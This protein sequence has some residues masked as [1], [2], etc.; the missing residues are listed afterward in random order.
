MRSTDGV[1]REQTSFQELLYGVE[2]EFTGMGRKRAAEICAD[3]FGT[4]VRKDHSRNY[5]R[6]YQEY[7]VKDPHERDWRLLYDASIFAEPSRYTC[8]VELVSPICRY[9]DLEQIEQLVTALKEKGRMK[10]NASC[11]LHV[12]VDGTLFDAKKLRNLVNLMASK[13]SLLYRALWVEASREALYCKRLRE[14]FVQVLNRQKP[15]SLEQVQAIWYE[16]MKESWEKPAQSRYYGLNLHSFFENG[17]IEYRM[18]PASDEPKRIR[19]MVEL[20]LMMTA[21]ALNRTQIHCQKKPVMEEKAAVRA[22]LSRLGLVGTEFQ[23]TRELLLKQFESAPDGAE[24]GQSRT[25]AE[26]YNWSR[27]NRQEEQESGHRSILLE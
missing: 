24:Q 13:E 17:S 3:Y 18:F 7:L 1:H 14:E 15:D 27:S 22:W 26:A 25:L 23:E 11:G 6:G 8:R 5:S 10:V 20:A 2:L 16:T 12:H 9:Q 19:A 4:A 21:Q